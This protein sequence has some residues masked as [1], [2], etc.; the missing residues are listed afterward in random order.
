MILRLKEALGRGGEGKFKHTRLHD[1]LFSGQTNGNA[2]G[3]LHGHTDEP[4]NEAGMTQASL[5]ARRL[6]DEHFDLIMSSDLT[7]AMTTAQTISDANGSLQGR[8]AIG[9]LLYM[10]LNVTLQ[11]SF[12]ALQM[13]A[14]FEI[15]AIFFRTFLLRE[16]HFGQFENRPAKEYTDAARAAGCN[17]SEAVWQ[18]FSDTTTESMDN[19]MARAENFMEVKL[20]FFFLTTVKRFR[21]ATYIQLQYL[22]V[23]IVAK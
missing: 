11:T 2:F 14:D 16:R 6:K 18:K 21:I 23:T 20:N 19:V 17:N 7:R 12:S 5:V 9:Y 13:S 22:L 1:F 15:L 10:Y 4:L 3:I 8:P